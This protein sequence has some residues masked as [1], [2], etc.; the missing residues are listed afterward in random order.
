MVLGAL[1]HRGDPW[2]Q[3]HFGQ[4]GVNAA[5][6]LLH[7]VKEHA[8]AVGGYADCGTRKATA[9]PYVQKLA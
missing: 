8:L 6:L 3:P 5:C 1:R 7:R 9:C 4:Y 2:A